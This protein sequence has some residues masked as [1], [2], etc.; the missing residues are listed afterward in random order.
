MVI[1]YS[2]EIA[3]DW[4]FPIIWKLFSETEL[5]IE[6]DVSWCVK[7]ELCKRNSITSSS[8]N[9]WFSQWSDSFFFDSYFFYVDEEEQNESQAKKREVHSVV[10][11]R[12]SNKSK[13]ANKAER[14]ASKIKNRIRTIWKTKT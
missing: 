4:Y 14:R 10:L 13:H 5:L 2:V 8:H 1:N 7:N 9:F 6:I 11:V 3:D 12:N